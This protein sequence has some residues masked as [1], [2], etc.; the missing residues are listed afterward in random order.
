M[1]VL[2]LHKSD[3][4]KH[5]QDLFLKIDIQPNVVVGILNGGGFVL[6]EFKK[7]A[8][9]TTEFAIVKLQRDSTNGIKKKKLLQ[10]FLKASPITLLDGLRRLEHRRNLNRKLK[11]IQSDLEIEIKSKS[12][13]IISILILD[14]ALDSGVT[15]KSVIKS[16]NKQFPNSEIKTA[17][18]SWT[19]PKSVVAP[20]FYAFK[21]TLVRFPWSLDYKTNRRG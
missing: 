9:A 12:K 3:F 19:N 7:N 2:T 21:N 11:E 13:S 14:D 5:C 17:V 18:I 10:T 8:S 1:K 4:E 15:I 20:D 6:E 16:L